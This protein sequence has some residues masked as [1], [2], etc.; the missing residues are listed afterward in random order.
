MNYEEPSKIKI[1]T[2]QDVKTAIFI[3]KDTHSVNVMNST[4]SNVNKAR[5]RRFY[6][7]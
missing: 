6:I 3:F 2:I 1:T 5:D 4:W 7:D